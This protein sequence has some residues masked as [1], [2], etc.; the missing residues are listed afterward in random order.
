MK[1]KGKILLFLS[2][3]PICSIVF[4]ASCQQVASAPIVDP[5]EYIAFGENK[6][7]YESI[8]EKM[9]KIV[10]YHDASNTCRL[11]GFHVV[12]NKDD[13]EENLVFP[14]YIRNPTNKISYKL[15]EIDDCSE[16]SDYSGG[17]G[18]EIVIPPTVQKI[19]K[20]DSDHGAFMR[21]CAVTDRILSSSVTKITFNYSSTKNLRFTDNS[22]MMIGRDSGRYRIKGKIKNLNPKLSSKELC[23]FLYTKG[24][25][26]S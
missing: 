13:C 18:G 9:E 24:L 23:D 17:L 19:G 7:S 25:P 1:I 6:D 12:S 16:I 26:Q 22:F 20:P 10:E 8:G 15:V 11:T 5:T 14:Q 3:L 21:Y 4:L 2:I